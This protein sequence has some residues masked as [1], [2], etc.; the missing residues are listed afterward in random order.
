MKTIEIEI[1]QTTEVKEMVT[2]EL[3]VYFKK[4][5]RYF[6]FLESGQGIKVETY[7]YCAE[8]SRINYLSIY[9]KDTPEIITELEFTEKLNETINLLR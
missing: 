9:F 4:D 3:P 6:S 8:V 5:T 1:T 2:V 7:P